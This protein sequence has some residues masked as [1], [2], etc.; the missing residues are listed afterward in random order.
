MDV[1]TAT[2]A[3]R[4]DELCDVRDESIAVAMT[5]PE[6]C[7]MVLYEHEITLEIVT[8]REAWGWPL[9]SD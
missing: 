8:V 7:R 5:K 3:K 1:G 6:E 4:K 2:A 9:P